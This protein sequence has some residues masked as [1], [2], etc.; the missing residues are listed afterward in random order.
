MDEFDVDC[1]N[2]ININ[3]LDKGCL[4][5]NTDKA[6]GYK[7]SIIDSNNRVAECALYWEEDFLNARIK[8]N[9][10]YHTKN[11]I[12]TTV[13]FC[14]EIL[15]EANNVNK[16][17][18]MAMLQQS[19]SYFKERDQFNLKDFEKDVLKEPEVIDAFRDYRDDF[20]KRMDLTAVEDFEVSATAVK[21]NA[22]Y[23]KTVIKL[24]KNFHLYIHA[25]HDYVERGFDEEKGLKFYKLF[26]VNE[27]N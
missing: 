22:K 13:G 26:Y 25:R 19:V 10:Y 24:D 2:G 5:F 15:T 6:A 27:E 8:A 1:D 7:L 9:A 12:D 17:D 16:E 18:Q 3:K 23:M 4:V 11:F 21:K 20:N 14:E